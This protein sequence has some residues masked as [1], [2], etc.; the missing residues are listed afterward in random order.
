MG[1]HY[2]NTF[3]LD[4]KDFSRVNKF[5]TIGIEIEYHIFILCY[6]YYKFYRGHQLLCKIIDI[7]LF[8]Q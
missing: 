3:I 8:K 7:I 4:I 2:S 1:Y 5:R 6:K